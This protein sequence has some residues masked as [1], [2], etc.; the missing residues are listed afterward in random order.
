MNMNKNPMSCNHF[1][2]DV[3][4]VSRVNT[5]VNLS[6]RHSYTRSLF[7]IFTQVEMAKNK[8]N[9]ITHVVKL[10]MNLTFRLLQHT[11]SEVTVT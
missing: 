10:F 3:S 11:S 7:V 5:Q 8:H 4:F 2:T 9:E 6:H 1:D